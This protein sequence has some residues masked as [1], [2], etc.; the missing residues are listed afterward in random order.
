MSPNVLNLILKV[1]EANGEAV[2]D[3]ED[4]ATW[5]EGDFDE[6]LRTGL[7][8]EAAPATEVVCPGCEEACLEDV[9]F[10]DGDRPED[11]RAYAACGRDDIGRVR[12]PLEMLD[13]WAVNRRQAEKLRPTGQSVTKELLWSD[14]APEFLPNAEAIKLAD[15]SPLT[16]KSLGR[17]LTPTGPIRYMRK[18]RRCKVHLQDFRAFTAFLKTEGHGITDAIIA[19][20]LEGVEKRKTEA[21]QSKSVSL[22]AGAPS[23]SKKGVG[24]GTA[25]KKRSATQKKEIDERLRN[26]WRVD[27]KS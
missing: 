1:L 18:G 3:R 12:I 6:A 17:L 23:K 20:Y 15:D 27:G 9:V 26:E 24:K 10:V 7:L 5:P 21:A 4:I 11:T 14:N 22:Q 25:P 13:R 16:I 8:E 19:A 2:F